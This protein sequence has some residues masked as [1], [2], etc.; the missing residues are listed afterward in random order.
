MRIL[1]LV[2]DA[3][4]GYGG[5]SQYNC[6][7]CRALSQS[8]LIA[9]VVVL[10]RAGQAGAL[11][12]PAKVRQ[13]PPQRNKFSYVASALRIA[14]TS[15][16][17]DLIFCGHI[18]LIPLA[19]MIGQFL[20]QPVWLQTHGIEAWKRP[21]GPVRRQTQRAALITTVSRH[22]RG[23]VLG[24]ANIDPQRIRVLP[25]T[26]RP[27]FSPGKPSPETLAKFGLQGKT[28][29]LTVARMGKADRYKGHDEVIAALPAVRSLYPDACYVVAGEGDGRAGLEAIATEQGLAQSVRFLGRLSDEDVLALY[30]S[31]HVFIMPSTKEGFGI[32]FVEAASTGLPVIAGNLDGS[33]DALADG[34]IGQL[35]DPRS[36]DEIVS[37]IVAAISSQ[38]PV[39]A[40]ETQRFAFSNFAAHVH[41]LVNDLVH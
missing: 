16:P 19:S 40:R 39:D 17:F 25:N 34:R 30:R 24:W 1:A 41:D 15:G 38:Q 12:L 32:V 31:A 27:L 26:V 9:E 3:Y 21:R 28:I 29:I 14:A 22:T 23:K 6:D 18:H 35:V 11:K 36:T 33:V 37:A 10:P 20:G 4:G 8:E 13:L 5:I 2:T 7:F